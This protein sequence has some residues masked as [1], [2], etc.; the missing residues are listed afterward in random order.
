M[1]D[2]ETPGSDKISLPGDDYAEAGESP[3]LQAI[4]RTGDMS[5]SADQVAARADVEWAVPARRKTINGVVP[6]DPYFADNQTTITPA[7][8]QWYLRAPNTTAVSAIASCSSNV[9]S[10]SKGL[11]R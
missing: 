4:I 6:N 1:A 5:P 3:G 8:G 2:S 9:L 11:M 10:S 7:V